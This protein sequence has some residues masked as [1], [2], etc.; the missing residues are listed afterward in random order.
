MSEK[1]IKV[2]EGELSNRA[3]DW[4]GEIGRHWICIKNSD[5]KYHQLEQWLSPIDIKKS[6]SNGDHIKITFELTKVKL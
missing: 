3:I 6:M 2:I 5:G 4:M 1:I